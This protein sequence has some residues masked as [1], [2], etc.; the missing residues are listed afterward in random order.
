MSVPLGVLRKAEGISNLSLGARRRSS[1]APGQ[2]LARLFQRPLDFGSLGMRPAEYALPQPCHVLERLHGL[3]EILERGTSIQVERQRV[4]PCTAS[5]PLATRITG[6]W[7]SRCVSGHVR[8]SS[9]SS[10]TIESRLSLRCSR[11]IAVSLYLC[12]QWAKNDARGAR[13]RVFF[14]VCHLGYLGRTVTRLTIAPSWLGRA[15]YSLLP[16]VLPE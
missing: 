6:S 4:N 15:I 8:G 5:L 7:K 2:R 9:E 11:A 12:K 1:G 14:G 16:Y 13:A 3:A 10:V